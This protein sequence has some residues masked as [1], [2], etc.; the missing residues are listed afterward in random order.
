MTPRS[1]CN[2]IA[3]LGDVFVQTTLDNP[4]FVDA[5]HHDSIA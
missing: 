3:D 2:A 1:P 4:F 5:E